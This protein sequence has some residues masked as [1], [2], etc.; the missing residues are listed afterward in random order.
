M[1]YEVYIFQVIGEKFG[2]VVRQISRIHLEFIIKSMAVSDT[3]TMSVTVNKSAQYEE[4][5]MQRKCSVNKLRLA[6]R[7]TFIT[8]STSIQ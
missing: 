2:I 1:T 4:K 3:V 6:S 8:L 5:K 7:F